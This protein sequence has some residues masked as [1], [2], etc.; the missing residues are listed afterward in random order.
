MIGF[1]L[2]LLFFGN[3]VEV[4]GYYCDVFGGDF[5][6]V[7]YVSVGCYDGLGDVIVYGQLSGLVEFVG[8]DVGVDD[9]VVQ[10]S[11]MFFLFFGM[12][13]VFMF[14]DWYDWFV[15]DGCVMDVLQKWLWGDFDGMFVDCYGICWL[16]GFYFED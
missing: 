4:F 6:L 11:G 7:D 12:V 15:V 13:D 2:Y 9:D 8:V 10:M 3:V 5:Q 16:I 14:I 1:I